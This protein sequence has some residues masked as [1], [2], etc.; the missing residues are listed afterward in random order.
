MGHNINRPRRAPPFRS[1][2]SQRVF[3]ALK[4]NHQIVVH[5]QSGKQHGITQHFILGFPEPISSAAA[6]HNFNLA[7]DS[8]MTSDNRLFDS[9]REDT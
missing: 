5:N 2:R 3:V 4:R 6:E 8:A 1:F 7:K 9:T